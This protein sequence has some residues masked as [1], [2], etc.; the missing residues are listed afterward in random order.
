M[1]YAVDETKRAILSMTGIDK[2]AFSNSLEQAAEGA[3]NENIVYTHLLLYADKNDKIFRYRDSETREADAVIINREA[4]TL[5]LI[6]IKSK[7]KIDTNR[8]FKNEAKHLFDDEVLQNIGIGD[9]YTISRIIVYQGESKVVPH[10]KG[11][12][13][14]SNIEEFLCN[15]QDLPKKDKKPNTKD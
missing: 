6:K 13:V 14:L 7:S 15:I 1:N 2:I 8:V 11:D 3:L 9:G 10:T 4:K 5:S 12:L